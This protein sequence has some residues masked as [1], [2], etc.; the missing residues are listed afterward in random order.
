MRGM[1]NLRGVGR[2][3]RGKVAGMQL[4]IYRRDKTTLMVHA[5]NA[6]I[7]FKKR[8]TRMNDAILSIPEEHYLLRS[9]QIIWDDRKKL[10][11]VPGE[12]V[13]TKAGERRKGTGLVLNFGL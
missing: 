13:L 6:E 1:A 11:V 9:K 3:T 4:I 5:K 12:Y 10:F 7:D 2:V 8:Q